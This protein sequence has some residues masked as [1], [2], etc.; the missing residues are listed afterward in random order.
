MG[1]KT[2]R[3]RPRKNSIRFSNLSYVLIREAALRISMPFDGMANEIHNL[4][5]VLCDQDTYHLRRA[6]FSLLRAAP[7]RQFYPQPQ[8]FTGDELR[9]A[10]QRPPSAAT[11]E[12]SPRRIPPPTDLPF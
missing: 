8:L 6:M 3:T 1:P 10:E 12:R 11:T 9:A 7:W 4:R 5:A 2:G